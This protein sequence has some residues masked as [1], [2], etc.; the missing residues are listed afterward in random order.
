MDVRP[1]TAAST[2][3]TESTE[4]VEKGMG[5]FLRKMWGS[6]SSVQN[7]RPVRLASKTNPRR[8]PHQLQHRT[9][10]RSPPA[11]A[12]RNRDPGYSPPAAR[13]STSRLDQRSSPHTATSPFASLSNTTPT[14]R[15]VAGPIRLLPPRLP[16][17][18]HAHLQA[19][20]LLPATAGYR[21]PM[22]EPRGR[23]PGAS[24]IL[25]PG[26]C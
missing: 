10:P 7:P 24:K 5:G 15:N 14:N 20:Q 17:P 3:S 22:A 26:A 12:L 13:P 19:R 11:R 6:K 4:S 18:A 8:P 2:S 16:L 9:V 23:E 1:E 21:T 25:W